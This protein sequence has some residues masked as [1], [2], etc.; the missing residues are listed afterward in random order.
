VDK[1]FRRTIQPSPFSFSN[2]DAGLFRI[3][4]NDNGIEEIEARDLEVLPFCGSFADFALS[5][6]AYPRWLQSIR[7]RIRSFVSVW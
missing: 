6:N 7:Q 2:I 4:V 3:P 1:E 5:A